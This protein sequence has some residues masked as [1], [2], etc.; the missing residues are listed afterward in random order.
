M[1]RAP[2]FY[3]I[4]EFAA[5]MNLNEG[6]ARNGARAEFPDSVDTNRARLPDGYSAIK[7]AGVCVIYD[8][9]DEPA[10]YRM[11]NVDPNTKRSIE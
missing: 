2:A 4:K 8:V 1:F 5:M 11:F 10:I 3:S 7:W 9:D 6:Y